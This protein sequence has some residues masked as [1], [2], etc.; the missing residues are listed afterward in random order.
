MD[1]R[2]LEAM[3]GK[4]RYYSKIILLDSLTM[5]AILG[6]TGIVMNLVPLYHAKR[7]VFPMWKDPWSGAWTGE[8]KYSYPHTPLII[9]PGIVIAL[10]TTIPIAIILIL[11][12]RVRSFRDAC[13]AI[14]GLAMALVLT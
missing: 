12:F 4:L 8:L 1:T 14:T 9:S 2:N 5:L 7:R 11:Q 6:L 3:S 10:V 13:A